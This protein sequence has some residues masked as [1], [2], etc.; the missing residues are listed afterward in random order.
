MEE[1]PAPSPT[2]SRGATDPR[3]FL[4]NAHAQNSIAAQFRDGQLDLSRFP[5]AGKSLSKVSAQ[6]AKFNLFPLMLLGALMA[7]SFVVSRT[8]FKDAVMTAIPTV[9]PRDLAVRSASFLLQPRN[10]GLYLVFTAS[11]ALFL[12]ALHIKTFRD[13]VFLIREQIVALFAPVLCYFGIVLCVLFVFVRAYEPNDRENVLN[14]LFGSAYF[15][16]GVKG[17][18]RFAASLLAPFGLEDTVLATVVF[19]CLAAFFVSLATKFSFRLYT[20]RLVDMAVAISVAA[21]EALVVLLC[22]KDIV[23]AD[24]AFDLMLSVVWLGEVCG[25]VLR[26]QSAFDDYN[27][28]QAILDEHVSDAGSEESEDYEDI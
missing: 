7:Y 22:K 14:E 2:F 28:C 26:Y 17:F 23:G 12:W 25:H 21:E 5:H 15:E 11:L 18:A 20:F 19:V 8:L 24:A 16:V 1:A 13:A 10:L 27:A 6:T 9:F 4:A 3:V